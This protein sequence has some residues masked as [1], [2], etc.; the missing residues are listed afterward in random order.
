MDSSTLIDL[1]QLCFAQQGKSILDKV[2]F[3]LSRKDILTIIGPNGAGKSTL[4][5]LVLGL[6]KPTSGSVQRQAKISIGYVPQRLSLDTTMPIKVSRFLSL[7]Q[8][9]KQDRYEALDF[10]HIR[11]LAGQQIHRLSGGELQRVLLARAIARKPDLLVLDEPLQ[12]VDVNGQ[13]E[14]YRLIASMRDRMGC[15]ILMVSHDLH[16]VMAQTDSVICLNQH[17]CC[18]GQPESVSQH[19]EY[20]KLFGQKAIDEI[21]VYQHHHDHHH[22]LHGEAVSC[23]EDCNHG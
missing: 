5:K 15:A 19:P 23:D 14:L 16:L 9:S 12:G 10:L 6:L 18:H 11:H 21:A 7:A 22:N 17:V 8:V 4:V 2:S 3:K 20:L 1:N 13:I